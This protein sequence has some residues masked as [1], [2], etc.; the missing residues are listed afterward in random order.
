MIYG[1][2]VVQYEAQAINGSV[3]IIYDCEVLDDLFDNFLN[4]RMTN[5]SQIFS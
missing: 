2:V 5:W 1:A 3:D 4:Y